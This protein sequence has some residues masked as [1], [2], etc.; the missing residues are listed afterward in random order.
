MT[1]VDLAARRGQTIAFLKRIGAKFPPAREKSEP[2]HE[3][4]VFI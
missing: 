3:T 1:L 4:A 2:L